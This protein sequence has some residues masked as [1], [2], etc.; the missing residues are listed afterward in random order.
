VIGKRLERYHNRATR[1]EALLQSYYVGT[2]EPPEYC[3]LQGC[4]T[5]SP[6]TRLGIDAERRVAG[7]CEEESGLKLQSSKPIILSSTTCLTP[8]SVAWR[9]RRSYLPIQV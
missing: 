1:S 5:Q 2:P 3:I 6:S 9:R 8:P 4:H 7:A